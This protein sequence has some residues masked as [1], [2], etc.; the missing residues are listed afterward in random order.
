M[1]DNLTKEIIYYSLIPVAILA[2][3][4]F[5]LLFI[6]KKSDSYYKYNYIIKTILLL[7]DGIVLSLL[8]GYSVW[9]TMRF[10]NNNTLSNNIIYVI[11]F[12]VLIVALILLLIT[13]CVKLYKSFSNPY[14]SW[15]EEKD[16]D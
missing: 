10:I 15:Y 12:A 9:A 7:I 11:L 6:K 1:F 4:A 3:F 8:I 5:I 2:I 16:F 13:T 14:N